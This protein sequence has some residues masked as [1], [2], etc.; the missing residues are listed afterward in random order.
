MF[1]CRQIS[2]R[3]S[4]YLD[5]ELPFGERMAFGIHLLMCGRCRKFVRHLG[6]VSGLCRELPG[7]QEELSQEEAESLVAK[8]LSRSASDEQED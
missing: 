3:S 8:V 6:Y 4:D 5:R 2:E 1:N 7:Q